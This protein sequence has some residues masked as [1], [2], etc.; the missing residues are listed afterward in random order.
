MSAVPLILYVPGLLPKPEAV[1]HRAAL[2]RCLLAGIATQDEAVAKAIEARPESFEIVSWTYDFYGEHRDFALDAPSVDA[3][4]AQGKL[5]P[6]DRQ[7]ASTPMRRLARWMF[8]VADKLPIL[9]PHI[10]TERVRL[11]L[12]DL[13]RYTHNRNELAEHTREM[14]KVALRS[15]REQQRPILLIAH[16]MGSVIAYESLWQMSRAN[17]EA[18]RIDLLLT[19][20]SPLGQ[21]YIQKLLKGSDAIG[22]VRYPANIKRWANLSAVG[23]L[24]A[25]DPY[26]KNDYKEMLQ[27]D[28]VEC[29]DD[30]IVYNWFR[31][32]GVL[33]THAEYGYMINPET[34]KSLQTGGGQLV[35][36]QSRPDHDID[37]AIALPSG[38]GFVTGDRAGLAIASR[39]QS[40]SRN[41]HR[42][43]HVLLH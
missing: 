27:A 5:S 35:L 16:S 38:L 36:I 19:M 42:V 26:L 32:D 17:R 37:S 18:M 31:L 22:A 10:A 28:L 9:I 34:A 21:S 41:S 33:N 6:R 25:I 13:R 43:N 2:L 14:L 4:L 1:T 12:R 40:I 11:H 15:A 8:T 39:N 24:T 7:E 29:I 30:R 20:G 3:L 23:D